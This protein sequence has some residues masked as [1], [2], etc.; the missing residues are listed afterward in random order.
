MGG[1]A[2]AGRGDE[3]LMERTVWKTRFWDTLQAE[4][5][6]GQSFDS[7]HQGSVSKWDLIVQQQKI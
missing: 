2:K 1:V 7:I 3:A 6:R 5:V 4:R